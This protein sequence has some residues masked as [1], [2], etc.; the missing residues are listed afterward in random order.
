MA[1]GDMKEI[2]SIPTSAQEVEDVPW[3]SQLHVI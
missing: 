3:G 2:D 1:L